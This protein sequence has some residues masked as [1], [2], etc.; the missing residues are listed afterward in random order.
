MTFEH[1]FKSS[2]FHL[3][4][5]LGFLP[6]AAITWASVASA[7][8][9]ANI[10]SAPT[11]RATPSVSTQQTAASKCK[12]KP[13]SGFATV[14]CQD[15]IAARF[16]DRMRGSLK[17]LDKFIPE[18]ARPALSAHQKR[19]ELYAESWLLPLLGKPHQLRCSSPRAFIFQRLDSIDKAL[20]SI[21]ENKPKSVEICY[22][23]AA[24]LEPGAVNT[25][26][27]CETLFLGLE[28]IPANTEPLVVSL[29]GQWT[30]EGRPFET[31]MTKSMVGQEPCET[32]SETGMIEYLR[33]GFV[34]VRYRQ[35][36]TCNPQGGSEQ[37]ST[38]DLR[39]KQILLISDFSVSPESF[40]NV[41]QRRKEAEILQALLQ[42]QLTGRSADV[43]IEPSECAK[44]SFAHFNDVGVHVT[45]DGLRVNRL[46]KKPPRELASCQFKVEEGISPSTLAELLRLKKT[47]RASGMLRY[48]K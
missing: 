47:S 26:T 18:G 31:R 16:L 34:S 46:F 43:H 4:P 12:Q 45:S 17:T 40:L 24:C 42:F 44:L 15:A 2:T 5:F 27:I 28:G 22:D 35:G 9:N 21:R 10:K 33:G 1:L 32:V 36:D 6:A 39:S 25:E 48:I 37:L 7:N 11:K 20:T 3:R 30:A 19:W 38:F 8:P 29:L 13:D 41:L 23:N 14:A